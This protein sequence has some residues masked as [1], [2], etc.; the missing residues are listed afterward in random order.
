MTGFNEPEVFLHATQSFSVNPYAGYVCVFVL[1][2][3][4]M[5]LCSTH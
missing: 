2:M 1:L 3:I 5:E 4:I